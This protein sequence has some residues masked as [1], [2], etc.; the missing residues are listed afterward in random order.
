MTE[1]WTKLSY[2]QVFFASWTQEKYMFMKMICQAIR[3]SWK[4]GHEWQSDVSVN[5]VTGAFLQLKIR[6]DTKKFHGKYDL[7]SQKKP[8]P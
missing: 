5:W 4:K 1:E 8:F 7:F 2:F 3:R 6:M